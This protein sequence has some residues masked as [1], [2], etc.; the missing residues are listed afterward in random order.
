VRLEIDALDAVDAGDRV[1]DRLGDERLDFVGRGA[2]VDDRDVDEREV[3]VGK[4]VDAEPRHR[5]DAEHHEAHDDHRGE[6]RTLDGG[7]GDPH[8]ECLANS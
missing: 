7:I 2:R 3:D 8:T 6:D 4:E 1:L 5:H